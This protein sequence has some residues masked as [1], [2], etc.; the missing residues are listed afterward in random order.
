MN[1]HFDIHHSLQIHNLLLLRPTNSEG[2]S[3]KAAEGG[4][5]WRASVH[6]I[7]KE[8]EEKERE[9]GKW[10]V[11]IQEIPHPLATSPLPI[12]SCHLQ[13]SEKIYPFF[14]KILS[15]TRNCG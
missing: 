5:E 15:T 14:N 6:I 2:L 11:E 3:C 8:R 4:R 1:E 10:V 9:L 12:S 7:Q 13:N